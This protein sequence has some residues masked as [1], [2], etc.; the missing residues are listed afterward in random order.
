MSPVGQLGNWGADL[1][2]VNALR[3]NSPPAQWSFLRKY[4]QALGIISDTYI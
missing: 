4:A 1:L 2:E 3:S